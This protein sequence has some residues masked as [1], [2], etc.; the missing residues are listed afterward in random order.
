MLRYEWEPFMQLYETKLMTD[1]I[2][3]WRSDD[4][5]IASMVIDCISNFINIKK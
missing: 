4:E 5:E 1:G 3:G 2:Y